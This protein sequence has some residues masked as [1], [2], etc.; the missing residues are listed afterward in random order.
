MSISSNSRRIA[1]NTL[2][3]YFRMAFT[4]GLGLFT[5]RVVLNELGVEDFGIYSVVAG[6]V[7]LFAF[8]P[9]T[10]ASAT[11]RFFSFALGEGDKEKLKSLFV[12]S[13]IIYAVVAITAFLLLE[14]LG[15]FFVDGYLKIPPERASSAIWLYHFSSLTFIASIFSAPL[16]AIIIAHEDMGLYAVISIGDAFLKLL[17]VVALVF[18]TGDKF[19]AYGALL[20]FF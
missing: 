16:M 17:A 2:M 3:L 6:V 10:M 1:K 9:G 14:T 15:L 18:L 7:T 8:L 11:Q 13:L 20:F 19:V 4:M 5:V 12:S